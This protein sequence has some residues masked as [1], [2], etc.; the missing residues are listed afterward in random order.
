MAG[1]IVEKNPNE[2]TIIIGAGEVGYATSVDMVN[3]NIHIE[4]TA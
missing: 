2:R 1:N 4:H 3:D